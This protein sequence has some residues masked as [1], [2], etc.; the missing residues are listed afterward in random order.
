MN[1][2]E[3]KIGASYSTASSLE[4]LNN[5]VSQYKISNP[6]S[7]EFWARGL[8]DTYKV[9]TD[10]GNFA[11]RVYRKNWRTQSSI[12]FELDVLQY[13]Q[14]KGA[15][16]AYPIERKE[17]GYIT[18]IVAPEGMRQVILTKYAEG[19]VLN[20]ENPENAAAYGRAAAQLHVL[21]SDFE[22]RHHRYTLNLDH[23]I[24]EPIAVIQPY[25]SHR[26]NDW[27]FLN[28]FADALSKKVMTVSPEELDYGFCHGDHHGFNAHE[29]EGKITFFDFD[30]C[31][32]GLR[33]YDIATFKWSSRLGKKEN[34]LWPK[35][36]EGYKSLREISDLNLSLVE[37]FVAIRNIWFL[38]LQVGN[39]NDFAKGWI[40]EAYID[41]HI[42]FLKEASRKIDAKDCRG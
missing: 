3:L 12:E 42:K 15:N 2:Q 25:L 4:L 7:C 33:A 23:L 37:S 27:E 14:Q 41:S 39:A 9:S 6:L 22:S 34:E 30:C 26:Q 24:T 32:F 38:A 11:L 29:Y 5:V 1:N 36:L 13:L 19:S 18:N 17:G 8:N 28:K 16:V 31:G 35:F 10:N 40:N 21:S 20:Y